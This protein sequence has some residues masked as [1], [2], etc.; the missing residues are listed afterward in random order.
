MGLSPSA[1]SYAIA[2]PSGSLAYRKWPRW[3]QVPNWPLMCLGSMVLYLPISTLFGK[4]HK[5]KNHN[6]SHTEHCAGMMHTAGGSAGLCLPTSRSA[7]CHHVLGPSPF[8]LSALCSQMSPAS[9][10]AWRKSRRHEASFLH[11]HYQRMP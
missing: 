3:S 6:R 9:V 2:C 8:S 7:H 11:I 5:E 10:L 1:S 4:K